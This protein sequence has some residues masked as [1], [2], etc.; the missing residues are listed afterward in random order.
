[1][2]IEMWRERAREGKRTNGRYLFRQTGKKQVGH[3]VRTLGERG[4]GGA[5]FL[6]DCPLS[7][8][9]RRPPFFRGK[10]TQRDYGTRFL[11]AEEDLIGKKRKNM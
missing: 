11:V 8:C 5:K 10:K 1:M 7:Y 2:E 9:C 6:P 3:V 4:G